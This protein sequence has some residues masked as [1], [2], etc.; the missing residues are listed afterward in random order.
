MCS[1]KCASIASAKKR[2][3]KSYQTYNFY[4][5]YIFNEK[6]SEIEERKKNIL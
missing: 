4:R 2:V 6:I 5:Y 1:H 3:N